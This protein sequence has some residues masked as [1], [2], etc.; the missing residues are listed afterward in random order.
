MTNATAG[1]TPRCQFFHGYIQDLPAG[2]PFDAVLSVLVS[3]FVK[4]DERQTYFQN[5]TKQLKTGGYLV[6]A[7][8]SCDLNSEKFPQMLKGWEQV[9]TLMGATPESLAGLPKQLREVLTVPCAS[10]RR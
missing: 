7:E 9:Q 6:N 4:L 8:I 10:F 3:H 5:M 2:E 1:W